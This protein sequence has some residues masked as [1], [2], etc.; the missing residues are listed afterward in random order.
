MAEFEEQLNN[1][2]SN[3]GAMSQIMQLAQS[4]SGSTGENASPPPPP[5]MPAA[6]AVS[7]PLSALGGLDPQLIA[8][9]LPL[10]RD[11]TGPQDSAARHL[12]FA[13]QPYLKEE[14]QSKVERALQLA[15]LF[16]VGRKYL[17]ERGGGDHV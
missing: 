11:L 17:L 15:R 6:P 14:R 13:L 7:D 12:L 4:L 8:R 16:R 10:I 3:P 9:A 1:I 2:L 5:P